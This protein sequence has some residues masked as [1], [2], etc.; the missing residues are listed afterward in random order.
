[1]GVARGTAR[2]PAEQ[3]REE[4]LRAA[5]AC[6][7][8]RGYHET[9]IDDI[10]ARAGLSKG[11]IYWHFPGK[12]ELFLALFDRYRGMLLEA[13]GSVA[14]A[15]TAS[16]GLRRFADV[17]MFELTDLVPLVELGLEYLAH[18]SRDEEM[19][20]RFRSLYTDLCAIVLEQLERGMRDGSFVAVDAQASARSLVALAD[21]LLV[22]KVVF[23][24]LDLAAAVHDGVELV[25]RGL[26]CTQ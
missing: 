22:Q 21:G 9:T 18:A 2:A 14:E 25:L 8:E 19:R 1:V 13:R 12:R 3:R 7:N 16:D 17:A 4:I 15:P 10:A 24:D 20:S 11:A 6:F 5:E 26:E 23:P